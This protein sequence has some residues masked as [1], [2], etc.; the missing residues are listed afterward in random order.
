MGMQADQLL[1]CRT[2]HDLE[3]KFDFSPSGH[4]G[5]SGQWAS[6]T[7]VDSQSQAFPALGKENEMAA[8]LQ[9]QTRLADQQW[10]RKVLS[11]RSQ[12]WDE[13]A[14]KA[15]QSPRSARTALR[16]NAREWT[17]LRPQTT[18]DHT[19]AAAESSP[20]RSR[21]LKRTKPGVLKASNPWLPSFRK[22]NLQK[23]QI[24]AELQQ[25][26]PAY[27][28]T[29]ETESKQHSM[30]QRSLQKGFGQAH[31]LPGQYNLEAQCGLPPQTTNWHQP[32]HQITHPGMPA[33]S[34]WQQI[35][36][37]QPYARL[38]V[39]LPVNNTGAH[40]VHQ[41]NLYPQAKTGTPVNL[42]NNDVTLDPSQAA[43]V[44][45]YLNHA[46]ISHNQFTTQE[47]G[48]IQPPAL[49]PGFPPMPFMDPR[50]E[51]RI[52]DLRVISQQPHPLPD[53]AI[54]SQPSFRAWM[55]EPQYQTR[56]YHSAR[57]PMA[58]RPSARAVPGDLNQSGPQR[59][60]AVVHGQFP[61]DQ[62]DLAALVASGP[63]YQPI[64]LGA[65]DLAHLVQGPHLQ[66]PVANRPA[67]QTTQPYSHQHELQPLQG[68]TPQKMYAANEPAYFAEKHLSQ[69]AAPNMDLPPG[70]INVD[71]GYHHDQQVSNLSLPYF[72]S[73]AL[74]IDQ[75]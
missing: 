50:I 12:Q 21:A 72:L 64:V 57:S 4:V 65:D 58:G 26:P 44:R 29:A 37:N 47:M 67:V 49:S 16:P 56:A 55:P 13:F 73:M 61:R 22:K 18:E 69:I 25:G 48:Q 45:A 52:W 42:H 28:D 20:R 34:A 59:P 24:E 1:R 63:Q 51:A 10:A 40:H 33:Q 54:S 5:W 15:I 75:A 14:E 27:R 41:H 60:K 3:P 9:Q 70:L 32:D 19:Q 7:K 39:P 62:V 68:L 53:H 66:F 38:H 71:A 30:Y 74:S 17:P 46:P 2:E 35:P 36:G 6:L 11:P 31:V 23:L 8:K 43:A